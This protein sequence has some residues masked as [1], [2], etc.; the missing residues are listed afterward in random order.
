MSSVGIE[1]TRVNGIG[2]WNSW[3][4]NFKTPLLALLDLFDNAIDAPLHGGGNESTVFPGKIHVLADTTNDDVTGIY[5]I[6]NSSAPIKDIRKILEVYASE[7]GKDAESIGE[8]GVGLKQGCATLSDMSF[9]L[10]RND[11]HFSLGVIAA[12]LQQEE[13]VYLPSFQF[14]T[15]AH[16]PNSPSSPSSCMDNLSQEMNHLFTHTHTTVGQCISM[17]GNGNMQAGID[18][19]IRHFTDMTFHHQWKNEQYVFS[20]ILHNLKH[21]GQTVDEAIANSIQQTPDNNNTQLNTN[22][23]TDLDIYSQRANGIL[24]EL[25]QELPHHYIHIPQSFTVIINR[26]KIHF[27]YWQQRLVELSEF[28]IKIDKKNLYTKAN[29]WVE[30]KEYDLIRIF[31]GFDPLR[32]GNK[33]SRST[34]T[35]HIYSRQSGRLIKYD[36]DAR[37]VLRLNNSGTTFCQGLSVIVDDMQ[38]YLPLNPTKQDIAFGEETHGEVHKNNLFAWVGAIAAFF[39]NHHLDRCDSRRPKSQL[40]ENVQKQAKL[41]NSSSVKMKCLDQGEFTRFSKLGW[42]RTQTLNI[43]VKNKHNVQQHL[44]KHTLK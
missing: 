13:G 28:Y 26:N 30:P 23:Q 3:T 18:R 8:N 11:H 39:Y 35:L 44:G 31:C 17:Y 21:G 15:I 20:V 19:L 16:S 22:K 2:L 36:E 29:D 5:M 1:L 25:E 42:F 4:R 14:K 41:I 38:G 32:L 34:C 7:K 33:D 37:A 10:I 40:Y 9:V 27:F 24:K 6:N 43:R 12:V